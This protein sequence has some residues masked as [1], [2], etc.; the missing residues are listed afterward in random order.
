[1]KTMKCERCN[2]RYRGTG[3]WNSNFR[4]GVLVSLLCPGCQTP[5]ENAE[6]AINEA[7]LRYG[8]D[9]LG[10]HVAFPKGVS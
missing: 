5:A 4:S 7:T 1:M 6:A 3:E 2:R 8:I 10:R 9:A